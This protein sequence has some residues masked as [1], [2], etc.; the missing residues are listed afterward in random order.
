MGLKMQITRILQATRR[1]IP[2][3]VHILP[4][5]PLYRR[6]LRAHRFHLPPSQRVLGDEYVKSE[7]RAHKSVDNPVQIVAFLSS[8]Q[9]YLQMI[10]GDK[11]RDAKLDMKQI[12]QMSDDQIIQLYELMQAAKEEDSVYA[13]D[14]IFFEPEDFH[15]KR[16]PSD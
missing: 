11:W 16:K 7:F 8:W 2:P 12:Q 13:K 6:I 14:G 3:R 4:P 5:L 9:N 15:K 1:T 10:E